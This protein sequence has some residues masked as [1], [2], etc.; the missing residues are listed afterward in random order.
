MEEQEGEMVF[1]GESGVREEEVGLWGGEMERSSGRMVD[2][3]CTMYPW[4]AALA[5]QPSTAT[6]GQRHRC[7]EAVRERAE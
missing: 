7:G 3:H 4:R 1:I 6:G 5:R 2:L